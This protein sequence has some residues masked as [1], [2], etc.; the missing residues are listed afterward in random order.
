MPEQ[1]EFKAEVD[2]RKFTLSFRLYL[3]GKTWWLRHSDDKIRQSLKTQNL[4]EAKE[5]GKAL[6][7]EYYSNSAN[8]DSSLTDLMVKLPKKLKKR[9][10][11]LIPNL[12]DVVKKA[13]IQ[14]L[15]KIDANSSGIPIP[16]IDQWCAAIRQVYGNKATALI[17]IQ[18]LKRVVKGQLEGSDSIEKLT[19]SVIDR[20][21]A[22]N[23]GLQRPDYET[24]REDSYYL[25][26]QIQNAKACFGI[27]MQ[28]K[29]R[30][31]F[32]IPDLSG[33][34]TAQ[35]V[36]HDQRVN[37]FRP[38]AP[39]LI[40]RIDSEME[41]AGGDVLIA[42]LLTRRCGMRAQEAAN[43]RIEWLGQI[44]GQPVIEVKRNFGDQAWNPKTQRSLRAIGLTR[45]LA[46]ALSSVET[47]SGY[48]IDKPTAHGRSAVMKKHSAMLREILPKE[49]HRTPNHDLRKHHG[50]ELL[51]Q[52]WATIEI[53]RR[54]GNSR[55]TCENW[56]VGTEVRVP[57][58]PEQ[59]EFFTRTG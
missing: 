58:A 37:N 10:I 52:G 44:K 43:A 24:V 57:D 28:R 14:E 40:A 18:C 33:F 2:G 12:A 8:W 21:V 59:T 5:R 11:E 53:A 20:F 29:L 55:E 32:T 31:Q 42:H 50:S 56:Y 45:E 27:K 26:T 7:R 4:G 19:E 9:A 36:K 15:A 41:K 48:L 17:Y 51:T 46:T 49:Y 39:A 23:Q 30:G 6:L 25:H 16:T 13:I 22:E 34:L 54:L 35:N 1:I 47:E 3:R 38:I